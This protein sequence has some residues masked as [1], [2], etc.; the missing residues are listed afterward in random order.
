[1]SKPYMAKIKICEFFINILVLT[2]NKNGR[3]KPFKIFNSIHS[4]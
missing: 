2:L 3:D 1:M 4:N